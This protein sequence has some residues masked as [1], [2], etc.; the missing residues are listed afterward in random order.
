MHRQQEI[1]E[2]QCAAEA[3]AASLQPQGVTQA[4]ELS[5]EVPTPSTAER[6]VG[7]SDGEDS[8]VSGLSRSGLVQKQFDLMSSQYIL[9]T[10]SGCF[11]SHELTSHI[12]ACIL[13]IRSRG[14]DPQIA[15][16]LPI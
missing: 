2:E 5:S 9:R 12:E 16:A 14:G 13:C 7:Q 4:D 3:S 15:E 8:Q 1:Y 11:A 6:A 10:V